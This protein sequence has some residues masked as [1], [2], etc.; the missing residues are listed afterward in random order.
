M[1]RLW[2][3]KIH[4][5]KSSSQLRRRLIPYNLISFSF[6]LAGSGIVGMLIYFIIPMQKLFKLLLRF[7]RGWFWGVWYLR[8]HRF[9]RL[10]SKLWQHFC[11]ECLGM[12]EERRWMGEC[13]GYRWSRVGVR[14]VGSVGVDGCSDRGCVAHCIFRTILTFVPLN[15]PHIICVF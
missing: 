4:Y 9:G 10:G 14:G 12:V 2:C 3:S 15:I 11:G 1:L 8:L 6:L 7:L 13:V 5:I